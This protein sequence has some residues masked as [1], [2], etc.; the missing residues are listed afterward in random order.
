MLNLQETILSY[1]KEKGTKRTKNSA[2]MLLSI[3]F[4]YKKQASKEKPKMEDS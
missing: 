1:S 4:H 2:E 3:L